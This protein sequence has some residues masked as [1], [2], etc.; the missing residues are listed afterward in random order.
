MTRAQF[1][2]LDCTLRDGG[3]YTDWDFPPDL[4]ESYFAAIRAL[5]V[6]AVEVGYR[7][8]VKP[9]YFGAF[10]HLGRSTLEQCRSALRDD[11]KMALMLNYKDMTPERI[12][13]LLSG[14]EGLVQIV[15]FA[16]P[17]TEISACIALAERV[18]ALG[19]EVAINVMYLGRYVATPEVLAPLAGAAEAVDHVALVDSYGGV[20]PEQVRAIVAAAAAMLPQRIGYHGHDNLSLAYANSLA[21]L[22]AGASMLD[23]TLLGMGRGAGNLKTELIA[24]T[25][26]R[27]APEGRPLAPLAQAVEAFEAL[28]RQYGWGTNLAYML[29]GLA[30]LPQADVMDW[31]GT[32]RYQM[33]S[34]VEALRLQNDAPVDTAAYR[35]LSEAPIAAAHG[36][37]PA[38]V[39]GG[40][41]S[42]PAHVAALIAH[43]RGAGAVVIH[44]SLRHAALFEGSGL[45]QVFC[46][47]G[48]E[49][50]RLPASRRALLDQP[51]CEIV[52]TAPPRFTRSVPESGS[53]SQVPH[54]LTDGP[55]GAEARLGPVPDDPPLDLA[56]AAARDLGANSL[57][58]A[59]FDGY[60]A[61]SLS[62]QRNARDVQ[63]A[64]GRAR[65]ADAPWGD[66]VASLTPTLY[67]VPVTSVHALLQP[68]GDA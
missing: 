63:E 40:G 31:L 58:L 26:E 67:E 53:I 1:D 23:A 43:A 56:T 16:C 37:A 27:T 52:T 47:A 6:A 36:G 24:L 33:D 22:E 21:A 28:Q 55:D 32:R 12:A 66:R 13:P 42:V 17:P 14:C 54:G 30:N 3:Y 2:I 4:L 61:A 48:Q 7:S 62:Q 38:L 64:I 46:L 45:P 29:S 60:A 65:Q 57:Y 49:L 44:S 9:G 35:P 10:F 15:R 8:P 68:G 50:D 39:I 19:F 25:R 5:P 34:I 18:K 59:G 51:G 11:Q 20:T 41:D